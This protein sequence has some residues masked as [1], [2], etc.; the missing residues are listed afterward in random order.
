LV[1]VSLGQRQCQMDAADLLRRADQ[2]ARLVAHHELAV[3]RLDEGRRSVLDDPER[4]LAPVAVALAKGRHEV[5]GSAGFGD[6]RQV[7]HVAVLE[8]PA[9]IIDLLRD[10]LGGRFERDAL[11]ADLLG[12][13]RRLRDVG[14]ADEVDLAQIFVGELQDRGAF[15]RIAV[16]PA[17]EVDILRLRIEERQ[18]LRIV[19]EQVD[20]VALKVIDLEHEHR[21]A[22]KAPDRHPNN[23]IAVPLDVT[24]PAQID[25]A[26]RAAKDRFGAIDVLVNNA[27]YGYLA[28]I[29]EGVDDDVRD[30]F[31]TNLFGPVNLL[32]AVLPAMRSR[33]HGHIVNISSIGG[34]VTY[35]GV[36]YYHMVK[37]AIEAMS[38]TL[39]KE[40][41]P[42]GIGVTVV[43]PGAF[44]T[45][46]RA[47]GSIKESATRISDYDDTAGKGRTG[48][49]QGHGKQQGD[50]ARGARAIIATVEAER[51]PIHLPIGGDALDQIRNRLDDMR[52]ETD[53]WESVIRSTDFET[54]ATQ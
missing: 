43:A 52:R 31:E 36:G 26:V 3:D 42:L 46:F 53:A 10:D 1:G 25:A 27:G 37:F 47:P 6:R 33:R 41:A 24:D 16:G 48:T 20:I 19:E 18:D 21:A 49:Q 9:A 30:L 28:A 45:D 54:I 32:K 7:E 8:A 22:A 11:P 44:R 40:V 2:V 39:A 13:R 4:L 38:D 12:E 5:V 34:L 17:L 14:A 51:S 35:A 29:E 23:A 15:R 50:P